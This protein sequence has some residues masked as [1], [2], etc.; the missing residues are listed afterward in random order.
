MM[1]M[2]ITLLFLWVST[3]ADTLGVE[4]LR[5]MGPGTAKVTSA[6]D[7]E[8]DAGV[9]PT[10]R[11]EVEPLMDGGVAQDEAAAAAA[12][13]AAAIELALGLPRCPPLA[14]ELR[15]IGADVVELAGFAALALGIPIVVEPLALVELFLP[16]SEVFLVLP[17]VVGVV[18]VPSA[19]DINLCKSRVFFS[20]SRLRTS[21]FLSS[22]ER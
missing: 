10:I 22:A 1:M 18:S 20:R 21:I 17:G 15:P 8:F 6:A 16:L 4:S 3:A 5:T 7:V 14:V 19:A 9:L 13:A 2:M 12:A 11:V